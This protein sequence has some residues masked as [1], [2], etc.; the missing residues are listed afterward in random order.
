[1]LH[2]KIQRSRRSRGVLIHSVSTAVRPL[3]LLPVSPCEVPYTSKTC[4]QT[5]PT[6]TSPPSALGFSRATA[7]V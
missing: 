6:V 5:R 2:T 4:K 7:R 1:M 3:R